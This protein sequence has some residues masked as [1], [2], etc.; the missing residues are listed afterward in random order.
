MGTHPLRSIEDNKI[1][2]KGAGVLSAAL[3]KNKGVIK[4]RSAARVSYYLCYNGDTQFC[5]RPIVC[6]SAASTPRPGL[7]YFIS[8]VNHGAQ[9]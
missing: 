2:D 3:S 9:L 8:S 1:T 7:R 6:L 5:H 4:L